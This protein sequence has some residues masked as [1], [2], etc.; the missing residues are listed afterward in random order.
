MSATMILQPTQNGRSRLLL[1]GEEA[2]VSS[3]PSPIAAAADNNQHTGRTAPPSTGPLR[4]Y[5]AA[6]CFFAAERLLFFVMRAPI[7]PAIS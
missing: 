5:P 6:A 2:P 1:S 4:P 7:V 3:I